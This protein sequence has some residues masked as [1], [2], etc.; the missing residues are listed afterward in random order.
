ML[1]ALGIAASML[2]LSS[3]VALATHTDVTTG[4]Y[5]F[6]PS[7]WNGYKVFLSAPTHGDSGSRGE[8]GWEENINGHH[9]SYYAGSVNTGSLGSFYNREYDVAVSNNPRTETEYTN[10]VA[11]A[12]NWGADVYIITHTNAN[13]GCGDGSSYLLVMPR[14]TVPNSVGLASELLAD[15][16]PATPGGQNSWNCDTLYECL[17]A[18]A[19][20]RAYVEL[21]FHTNLSAVNWFQGDG[22]E[23]HG[24]VTESWRYGT[25]VDNRLGYPR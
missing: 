3:S 22:V 14:S 4:T 24:G 20:H 11:Y 15:L 25:A 18:N 9:W 2:A 5:T 8:C 7:P 23:G 17:Y 12:N 19:M 21:F 13:V 10:H 16:D 6:S 1:A